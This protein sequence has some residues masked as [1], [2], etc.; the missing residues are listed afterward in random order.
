F[1]HE[2]I[3]RYLTTIHKRYEP[4]GYFLPIL[5]GGS[6]PWLSGTLRVLFRGWRRGEP[7]DQF[8]A[9][10]FT[11]CWAL[12]ILVFFSFSDSKLIPYIEPAFPA[13]ALLIGREMPS[14][15]KGLRW[16]TRISGA[17]S[18]VGLAFLFFVGLERFGSSKKPAYLWAALSPWVAAGL[19]AVLLGS[20]A[21]WFWLRRSRTGPAIGTLG[22]AWLV[23]VA[24]WLTGLQ[25]LAPAFSSHDLARKAGTITADVPFYSV[26]TYYQ[27]VPFYFD[28]MPTL[29]KFTGELEFGIDQAPQRWVPTIEEFARRWRADRVAWAVMPPKVFDRLQREQL[30]M[31][32]VARDPQRVLVTKP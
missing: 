22:V 25:G 5:V 29:V 8:D 13:L 19:L 7:R 18:A 2:H 15:E 1:I 28:R 11:W 17:F 3:E 12:T 9:G 14:W 26:D 31:R 6:L 32:E 23:A 27:T 20:L 4:W 30:P 24:L 16:D 10:C 21:A